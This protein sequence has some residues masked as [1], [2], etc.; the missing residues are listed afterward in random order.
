MGECNEMKFYVNNNGRAYY[1]SG[2]ILW[3]MRNSGSRLKP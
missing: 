1:P 3:P 2:A